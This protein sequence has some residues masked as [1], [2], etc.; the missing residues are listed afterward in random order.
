[1]RAAIHLARRVCR[2]RVVSGLAILLA[3]LMASAQP[4]HAEL[5]GACAASINGVDLQAVSSRDGRQAIVLP[6]DAAVPVE[7]RATDPLARVRVRLAFAGVQWTVADEPL[8]GDAW[9]GVA[10]VGAY[11]RYGV[12]LYR[13]V[14]EGTGPGA[15][16]RGAA[17]VRVVG[18]PLMT[19]AGLT[20]A[21]VA[22]A[23]MLGLVGAGLLATRRGLG[24]LGCLAF[25]GS[26]GSG[27]AAAAGAIVLLQQYGLLYPTG[28]MALAGLGAGAAGGL[29]LPALLRLITPGR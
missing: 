4:A 6:A 27:I 19:A 1:M 18:D 16:C 28:G 21:V 3:L 12:G 11:A 2:T 29:A 17:L 14:G 22:G 23:G 15:G 26:L 25:L 5:E 13:V 9:T 8:D 10:P 20:A 7:L 24:A